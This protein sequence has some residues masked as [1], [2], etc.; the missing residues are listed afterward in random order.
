LHQAALDGVD[1]AR[2]GRIGP[3]LPEQAA[4]ALGKVEGIGGDF[5]ARER[6]WKPLAAMRRST[7]G[8]AALEKRCYGPEWAGV[9]GRAG[10]V[11]WRGPQTGQTAT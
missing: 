9:R 10:V 5:P 3:F 2:R 7:I 4:R 11:G 8:G 1:Q 6:A